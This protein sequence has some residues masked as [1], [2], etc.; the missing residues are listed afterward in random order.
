MY[1]A[2]KTRMNN[3]PTRFFVSNLE[4]PIS[5]RPQVLG[6][7]RI[8]PRAL[9]RKR[10]GCKSLIHTALSDSLSSLSFSFD[11]NKESSTTSQTR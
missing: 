5:E 9:L 8:K 6:L 11:P 1:P 7:A 3:L 2:E 10:V 4:S